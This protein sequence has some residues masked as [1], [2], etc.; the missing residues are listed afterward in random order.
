MQV[1]RRDLRHRFGLWQDFMIVVQHLMP[2]QDEKMPAHAVGDVRPN[3]TEAVASRCEHAPHASICSYTC[4]VQRKLLLCMYTYM[5]RRKVLRCMYT[6]VERRELL[7]C[8]YTRVERRSRS[9]RSC[10][11]THV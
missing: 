10:V 5:E 8:M 6:C 9:S 4:V 3:V 2:V 7:L 11:C 1:Q